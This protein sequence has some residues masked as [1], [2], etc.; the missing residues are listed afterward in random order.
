MEGEREK[1]LFRIDDL[2]L[3]LVIFCSM[4]AGIG[5]PEYATLFL[6]YPLYL[7]MLLLFLSFLKIE[8]SN[9]LQE[10]RK[11][12]SILFVLCL[13]KLL[14]LPTGL[15]FLTRAILPEYALP[16][17]LLSGISTGV[18]APFISGILNASTLPVL[19]MVI[20]SSLLVPFSLPALV[21]LLAGQTIDISFLSMVKTLAMLVFL[22]ALAAILLRRW[23]PSFLKKLDR[24]QFPV[25][26]VI[27]A[28]INLG[29]FGRYSS[30]FRQRPGKVVETLIVAFV[31]SAVYHIVGFMV[32]WGRRK[33]DR[34]AGAISLA[35]MNNVLIVVFS[36]QFFGP[37]SPTLAA[38]YILPFFTMIVPAR[39]VGNLIR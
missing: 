7:L 25:S 17:L 3:L 24:V 32:T 6:P 1:R 39:I 16:V 9:A 29:V 5:L 2:I 28:C 37:L 30:Y 18:V 15:Y 21:E 31:L 22:P 12:T 23:V 38:V 8:F 13:I 19:M 4:A 14:V 34:L 35:Y 11:M 33:E 26:L 10:I 27:F 20:V 36:S